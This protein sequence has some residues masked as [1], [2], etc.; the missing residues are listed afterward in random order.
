MYKKTYSEFGAES[1]LLNK[2]YNPSKTFDLL[3]KL[4]SSHLTGDS[5]V[6]HNV[7]H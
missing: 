3:T 6:F 4:H 7:K 2:Y 5:H 1:S